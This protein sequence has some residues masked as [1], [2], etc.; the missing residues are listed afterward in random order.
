MCTILLYFLVY[1]E[2]Q[3]LVM[4]SAMEEGVRQ[5]DHLEIFCCSLCSGYTAWCQEEL[6]LSLKMCSKIWA[7]TNGLISSLEGMSYCLPSCS[8]QWNV[9][10]SVSFCHLSPVNP[11]LLP[12]WGLYFFI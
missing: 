5:I 12:S 11:D 4:D 3:S 7:P 2:L 6:I 10:I 1:G 9:R 8:A